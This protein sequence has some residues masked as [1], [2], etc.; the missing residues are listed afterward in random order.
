MLERDI[1]RKKA[2]LLNKVGRSYKFTSPGCPGVPDRLNLKK[3]APE[4]IDIVA[5]Y[6]EFVEYKKPGGKPLPHQKR[7]HKRIREL[8]F[9]VRVIDGI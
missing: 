3:I 1:E 4:H 5:K 7:E 6:I 8:G 9:K 2:K